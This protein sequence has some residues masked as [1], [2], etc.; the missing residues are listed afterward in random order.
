MKRLLAFAL[1]VP[2]AACATPG[3]QAPEPPGV[4]PTSRYELRAEETRTSV[5]LAVRDDGLSPAQRQALAEIALEKPEGAVVL[6]APDDVRSRTHAAA[7]GKFLSDLGVREVRTEVGE[8]PVVEVT[9]TTV[10]AVIPD[11]D[12][13]WGD[14][15]KTKSNRSHANFGC[16]V[17][18]NIMAQL[19]DPRDLIGRRA[20]TPP[21]AARRAT[22][23]DNYRKGSVTA[24]ETTERD[25]AAIA[26]SVK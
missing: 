17:N 22:V 20:E 12:R 2:L 1:L 14:M 13:S 4:L 26:K 6:R 19:A 18:A 24:A 11:C 8:T 16:A 9:W 21:D 10:R 7:A 5:S 3:A 25:S 15:T 23:I